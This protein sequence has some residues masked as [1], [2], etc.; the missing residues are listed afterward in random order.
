MFASF[1]WSICKSG[2]IAALATT[3]AIGATTGS[4]LILPHYQSAS[5]AAISVV[6]HD[7]LSNY[8]NWRK[9]VRFGEVWAPSVG[10][11]W[12]PYT[13][14]AWIWTDDG[15]YWQSGE[16]FGAIVFHYGQWAYDDDLGWVL[17][18]RR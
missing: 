16:P 3:L 7:R 2:R 11:N 15:W 9:S 10:I 5:A 1:M 4:A 6:T 17:G 14:G 18:P 12:R 13:D 8:G